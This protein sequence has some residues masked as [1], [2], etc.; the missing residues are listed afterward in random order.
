ML[1]VITGI[2]A[3]PRPDD[4]RGGELDRWTTAP[5]L[6]EYVLIIVFAFTTLST[7]MRFKDIELGYASV[8]PRD[9]DPERTGAR[10]TGAPAGITCA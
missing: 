6:M 3:I 9:G 10:R 2:Y 8:G 7:Y 5:T 1:F 4:T